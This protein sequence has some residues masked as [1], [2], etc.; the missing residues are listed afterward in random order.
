MAGVVR[1]VVHPLHVWHD[2]QPQGRA[3]RHRRLRGGAGVVDAA[4]LLRRAGRDDVHDQRHRLGRR[5]LVHRLRSAHQ[6][7][8]D[9]LLR[10]SANPPGPV[11]LV[12]DR[13][14]ERRP[15]DVQLADRDPRAE[16]AGP[17]VHE[18]ARCL[19]AALS[20]SRRRAAGRAD[21][22]LGR[23]IARR[24]DHRQ[25]LADRDR[26]ADSLRATRR[27]RHAAQVRLAVVPRVRLRREAAARSDRDGSRRR[28]KGRARHRPAVAARLHDDGMGR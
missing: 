4:N 2:R 18:A 25:L 9:D 5:P 27:R 20:V 26:L 8:D 6:R 24:I 13:R 15:D 12:E 19:V 21:C 10:G 3:A 7:L 14:R 16:E 1:G 22:A 17:R 28:R 11:D 23:G